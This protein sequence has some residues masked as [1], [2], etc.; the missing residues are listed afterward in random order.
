MVVM[1]TGMTTTRKGR[2]RGEHVSAAHGRPARTDRSA[3]VEAA[4]RASV[5]V[6]RHTNHHV[7]LGTELASHPGC[8]LTLRLAPV[9]SA[10][11]HVLPCCR[12]AVLPFRLHTPPTMF[13][14]AACLATLQGI[15]VT[16]TIPSDKIDMVSGS[17]V[18]AVPTVTLGTP[19]TPTTPRAVAW[20]TLSV[21][22]RGRHAWSLG[23][24][25]CHAL[26]ERSRACAQ[27]RRRKLHPKSCEAVASHVATMRWHRHRQRTDGVRHC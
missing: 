3:P 24:A 21:R 4:L 9:P 15:V 5:C 19:T 26:G 13:S 1:T 12:A 6:P 10:L 14:C 18:D 22:T 23:C 17:N 8:L 2:V 27:R 16:H 20:P 7:G 11:R 25:R